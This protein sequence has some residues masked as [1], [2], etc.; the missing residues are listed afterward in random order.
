MPKKQILFVDDDPLLLMALGRLFRRQRDHWEVN[1]LSNS[2]EALDWLSQHSADLV[3]TDIY[4][5]GLTGD[6]FLQRVFELYP[7]TIRLVLSGHAD[8][9]KSARAALYA[10][11]CLAKPCDFG[12]LT[13]TIS[14]LLNAQEVIQ[15][16]R[17]RD[18]IGSIGSLPSL[19]T[20]FQELMAAVNEDG[21]D[22]RVVA[23]II[24]KD[25][26]MS[27]KLLQ[28]VNSSFFGLGR[29]V[30]NVLEA[31]MLI[32][33]KQIRSLLLGAYVFE[34]FPCHRLAEGSGLIETLWQRSLQVAE[35]AQ[36]ISLA[37]EQSG[38]R[39]DQAYLGGLMHKIGLLIFLSRKSEQCRQMFELARTAGR[40]VVDE[41]GIIG[42]T[43][44]EAGA[45]LM[46]LWGL[47]SRMVEAI[48]LYQ[49]PGRLVYD[50]VCAVTAVHAASALLA[51]TSDD[52]LLGFFR[53]DLDLA[54]LERI[55]RSDHINHW[56]E[57]ASIIR[58]KSFS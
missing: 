19:P 15:D 33:V 22:H 54:Y 41:R 23:G 35:L 36:A 58:S 46:G 52:S 55:Q 31:V 53:T 18:C 51:E 39:P 38:D 25:I 16:T 40:D 12:T 34:V 47:P 14:S 50:G 17:V 49:S 4:M 24:A 44:A 13:E 30:S 45:Y 56:R 7:S 21:C 48:L 37:E 43:H 10:H 5:P 57:L 20:M 3:V 9:E 29:R 1:F 26:A 6:E 27:A 32:G 11:Q 28:L 8:P 2:S 42:V